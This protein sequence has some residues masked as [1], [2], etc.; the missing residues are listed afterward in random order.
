MILAPKWFG[1]LVTMNDVAAGPPYVFLIAGPNGAGKST[2]AMEFL[3]NGIQCLNFMNADLIAA[4]LSPFAPNRVAVTAG[5]M[6]ITQIKECVRRRETLAIETTLS[7]RMYARLIPEWRRMGYQ[8]K[9]IFLRLPN[10][11]FARR[12]VALRVKQGGHSVE[13]RD[14]D[15]RFFRGLEMLN[16]T[17]L[18]LVDEAAVY[19]ASR[20][21]PM[22]INSYTN[23]RK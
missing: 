23:T 22:L 17:Y 2:F 4:G 21:P 5:R 12:R 11:E 1:D 13:G 9:L 14:I 18:R 19:D 16:S 8:V 7:G 10:P 20:N 6:L 15:R 3:P